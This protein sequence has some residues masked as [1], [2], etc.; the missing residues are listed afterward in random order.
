MKYCTNCGNELKGTAK[1]CSSC[2]TKIKISNKK[3]EKP[4][5]YKRESKSLK[6]KAKDFGKQTAQKNI[7]K[8]IQNQA[9]KN[10]KSKIEESIST[11]IQKEK[12]TK[13]TVSQTQNTDNIL[14]TEKKGINKWTWIYIIINALLVILGSQSDE[15]MGVLIFSIVIIAIVFFRRK[16][17]KPYNWFV[18]IIQVI[19]MVLLFALIAESIEYISVF[20]LVFIG[21]LVI[22]IILLFK[23]NNS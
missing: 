10:V 4:L 7:E 18:K 11:N 9:T 1:F 21:L 17:E 12:H 22:N 16:K 6:E 20:T 14:L 3:V 2:G 23:G 15:V 8:S 13:N 19:Q 5:M